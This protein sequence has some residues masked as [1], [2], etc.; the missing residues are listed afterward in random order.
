MTFKH[1]L[2][3]QYFTDNSVSFLKFLESAVLSRPDFCIKYYHERCGICSCRRFKRELN[4]YSDKVILTGLNELLKRESETYYINLIRNKDENYSR[5]DQYRFEDAIGL[6]LDK[7][8]EKIPPHE[9]KIS[10]NIEGTPLAN[11]HDQKIGDT[12]VEGFQYSKVQKIE[13]RQ[14]LIK[15]EKEKIEA[16]KRQVEHLKRTEKYKKRSKDLGI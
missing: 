9:I 10:K 13:A 11:F 4:K 8:S 14:K 12:I 15:Q 2:N 6:C 3:K 16:K 7:I 5:W 1:K